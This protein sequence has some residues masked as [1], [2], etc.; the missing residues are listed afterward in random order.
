MSHKHNILFVNNIQCW[1]NIF[2]KTVFLYS[3]GVPDFNIINPS[4]F[5]LHIDSVLIESVFINLFYH[6]ISKFIAVLLP[7]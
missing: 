7:N 4:E 6:N 5:N 1:K 3:T 2:E